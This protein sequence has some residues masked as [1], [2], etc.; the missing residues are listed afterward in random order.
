MAPQILFTGIEVDDAAFHVCGIGGTTGEMISFTCK[1]VLGVLVRKLNGL[2]AKGFTIQSCYEASY[3]GFSLCRAL[4]KA[5]IGC[6]V[7]APSLTPRKA[8][9]RVKT[10]RLDSEKLATYY[11]K[12][13][14]TVVHVPDEGEEK[15]RDLI[16]TRHFLTEQAKRVRLHLTGMCRRRGWDYRQTEGKD[17]WTQKH[18]QWLK[19]QF[20]AEEDPAFVFHGASLLHVLEGLEGQILLFS[21]QIEEKAQTPGYRPR[22]Q[23]LVSFRG[24]DVI[25]AMTVVTEIGDVHRFSHPRKLMS[26]VGF[27]VKEYSSGGKQFQFHITKLGNV[28]LRRV[29]VESCQTASRPPNIGPRL[30]LRRTGVALE[31]ISIAD[32]CM[33]RLYQKSSRLLARDKPR[34]KVKVACARELIG[35]I[36]RK[37]VV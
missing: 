34:N 18:R 4:R 14:L 6:E 36:D 29:L 26:F 7:I 32:R 11:G 15:L 25:T 20:Q 24:I 21:Q 17:T 12:G 5:G 2:G 22:V 37:S 16:R 19:N 28:H 9:D 13:L 27:D 31:S 3:I 35:F 10:D 30:K 1:P 33:R 23:G 8:G